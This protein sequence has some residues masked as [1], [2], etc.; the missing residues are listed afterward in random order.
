M[1]FI[2]RWLLRRQYGTLL[3]AS[4]L[5]CV[6]IFDQTP[7]DF[8]IGWIRALLLV[9]VVLYG[10]ILLFKTARYRGGRAA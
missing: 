2:F 5:P 1:A 7:P 8:V 6:A 4:T 9:S 10:S 3:Y